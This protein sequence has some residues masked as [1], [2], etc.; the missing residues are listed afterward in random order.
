MSNQN[1]K[2]KGQSVRH[3]GSNKAGMERFDY[4]ME[5]KQCFKE[6]G[7]GLQILRLRCCSSSFSNKT[8]T[9]SKPSL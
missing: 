8:A 1:T 2:C 7:K 3:I 4:A 6:A 5:F 9:K